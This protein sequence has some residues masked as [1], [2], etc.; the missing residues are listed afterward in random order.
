MG[1]WQGPWGCL[2][3]WAWLGEMGWVSSLTLRPADCHVASCPDT[4]R[5]DME[6]W[7][8]LTLREAQY[9]CPLAPGTSPGALWPGGWYLG[10]VR[11]HAGGCGGCAGDRVGA[12]LC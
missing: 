6:G 8:G 11:L 12:R 1:S 9:H 10:A 3:P 7:E 5:P 2:P 4:M